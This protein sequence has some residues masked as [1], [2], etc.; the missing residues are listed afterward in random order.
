MRASIMVMASAEER[1]IRD[2]VARI[3]SSLG[4]SYYQQ[5]V[6]GGGNLTR[7]TPGMYAC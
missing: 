3:A 5:H 2:A 7:A 6:D 4:P 1:A